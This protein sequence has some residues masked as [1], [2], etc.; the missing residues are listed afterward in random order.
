MKPIVFTCQ[1]TFRMPPDDIARQILDLS[2]WP[3]FR[4]YGPMPGIKLAEFE[5]QNPSIV[6]SRIRVTNTDDSSH[7]EE[8]VEWEPHHRVRLEMKDFSVPLSKLAT[9]F[10]E[11][12]DFKPTG[13]ETHVTRSFQLFARSRLTWLF[14]WI[15]S[16][17]LK[18]AIM[19]H[20]REMKTSG[21]LGGSIKN[22]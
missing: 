12:W 19:R 22:K 11:A 20:L 2:K 18:R 13:N 10:E 8:I 15:I 9:R 17:F 14:L 6:G 7:V 3:D 4:G 21:T 16:I 5:V 1:E